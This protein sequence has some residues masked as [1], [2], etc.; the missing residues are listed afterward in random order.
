MMLLL[1]QIPTA[2]PTGENAVDFTWLFIRMLLM[3]G[4]VSVL[5]ILVLKYVAPRIGL[6]KKFQQG[7]YF[8]ILGRHPLGQKTS[9]YLVEVGGR[10][11][12]IGAGEHG[13]NTI[14]ELSKDEAM[15]HKED[16]ECEKKF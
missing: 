16:G 3:L 15:K 8:T 13:I 10:Y 14:A 2:A 5:A 7:K 6:I 12:V 4:I 1:L 9:L 11:F